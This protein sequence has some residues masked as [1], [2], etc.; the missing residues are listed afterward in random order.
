M[1]LDH[2]MPSVNDSDSAVL[3]YF[4]TYIVIFIC[5]TGKTL[6]NIQRFQPLAGPLDS[7]DLLSDQFAAL[8]E[9]PQLQAG[10]LLLG[11]DN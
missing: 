6:K 11:P 2:R 1:L 3:R 4:R 5:R 10:A 7:A 9:Q 8:V